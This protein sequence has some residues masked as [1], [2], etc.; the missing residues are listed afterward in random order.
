MRH[1]PCLPQ[2]RKF[3]KVLRA[4]CLGW[5]KGPEGAARHVEELRAGQFAGLGPAVACLAGR[6]PSSHPLRASILGQPP[7][8]TLHP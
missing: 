4:L 6:D 2:S 3:M 5:G 1:P 8:T 7:S